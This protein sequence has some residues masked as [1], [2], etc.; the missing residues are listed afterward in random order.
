MLFK[1]GPYD[2]INGPEAHVKECDEY[3]VECPRGCEDGKQLKRKELELHLTICKL[4]PVK[5]IFSEAGCKLSPQR[6]DVAKHMESDTQAYLQSCLEL[7]LKMEKDYDML[8]TFFKDLKGRFDVLECEHDKLKRAH[9][10]LQIDHDNLKREH[11]SIKGSMTYRKTCLTVPEKKVD[12]DSYN[13]SKST[14]V[15]VPCSSS[16]SYSSYQYRKS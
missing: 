10:K 6:K 7:Q 2:E 12:L 1:V 4:E 8:V 11:G 14:G 15:S 5:C 9:D 13:T 16:K 3:P